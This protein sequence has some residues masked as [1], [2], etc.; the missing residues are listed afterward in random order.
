MKDH[1]NLIRFLSVITDDI[2]A[3]PGKE[4]YRMKSY[5]NKAL[6]PQEMRRRREE[7][8]IQ[9]RKQKREEQVRHLASSIQHRRLVSRPS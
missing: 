3:S 7:E 5:K 1:A 4:N 9:L 6:N 2:M 8:G